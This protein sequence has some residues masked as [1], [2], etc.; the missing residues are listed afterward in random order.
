[1]RVYHTLKPIYNKDSKILIL[2]SIPSPKS[3]EIGF[4][5]GHPQNKF[6]RILSDV[7]NQD[8]PQTIPEKKNLLLQHHIALWDVLES[9]EINGAS[10]S[11]IKKPVPNNLKDIIGK[12]SI[13]T[14][15]V[16]G[17]KAEQLYNKFCLK[18]T[19]IPCI[20]L[21]ST[22]PANASIKYSELKK[23]YQIILNYLN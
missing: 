22:S 12:S 23:A 2:G 19:N 15:F 14:I 1:M 5:Y 9:C 11:S 8:L 16:T 4:Y 3:R 17:K 21:P 18:D 20:Y 10:D 7:L 13:E 6:W